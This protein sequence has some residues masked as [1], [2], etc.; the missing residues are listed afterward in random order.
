MTDKVSDS[1]YLIFSIRAVTAKQASRLRPWLKDWQEWPLGNFRLEAAD[2]Q[3]AKDIYARLD[4]FKGVVRISEPQEDVLANSR[5][6]R[7]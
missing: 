4:P 2:E 5:L 7:G 3:A 6:L 1:P